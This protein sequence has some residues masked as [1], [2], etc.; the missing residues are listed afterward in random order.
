MLDS[1]DEKNVIQ[2]LW[3]QIGCKICLPEDEKDF[4]GVK[5]ALPILF[6]DR[7]KFR[8]FYCRTRGLLLQDDALEAIYIGDLSRG[9]VSFFCSHQLLP[10]ERVE[11]IFPNGEVLQALIQR[12]QKRRFRCFLCGAQIKG[13][14]SEGREK[15]LAF[16]APDR[17]PVPSC[18]TDALQ[19]EGE[20]MRDEG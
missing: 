8:R 17:S 15:C 2:A 9:G 1:C 18:P 13:H 12:C 10:Q 19:D 16:L 6:Q 14:S 20:R 3:E 4:L 5:G 11:L 7:R